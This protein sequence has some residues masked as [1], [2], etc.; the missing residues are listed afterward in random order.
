MSGEDAVRELWRLF[1]EARFDA[2]RPLLTDN[3]VADWPQTRERISGP[4]NFIALNAAY[5]GRWRCR[6]CHLH[7]LGD[8][9]IS[10]VELSDGATK[11]HVVSVYTVREGHLADAREYFG[12]AGD[13]PY[14]RSRWSERY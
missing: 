8:T 6:L 1:D 4:D 12:D 2:V 7:A 9:V 11:V 3:F 14:N 10:E 13:P 5:P